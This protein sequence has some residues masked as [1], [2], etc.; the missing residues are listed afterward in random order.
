MR[1]AFIEQHRGEFRV[2]SMCRVLKVSRSGFYDWITRAPSARAIEDQH[3]IERIAQIHER[4]RQAYGVIKI[5]RELRAQGTRCGHNRIAR[6]K[7]VAGIQTKRMRRFRT[8]N[9][10]LQISAALGSKPIEPNQSGA[11]LR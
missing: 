4:T 6:L 2:L 1:Y 9:K 7:R 5:Q 8:F 10:S 3:L 11:A